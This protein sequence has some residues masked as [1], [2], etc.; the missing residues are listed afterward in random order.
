MTGRIEPVVVWQEVGV[1]YPEAAADALTGL[2]HR[3]P[4]G[5]FGLL[6]G[7]TGSGKSTVLHTVDASVPH[8]TGGT[9]RG[10]VL[11]AGRDT[12]EYAPR[13]LADVVAAVL[14]RPSDGFVADTVEDE[15]AYGMECLG[16]DPAVM[17]RRVEETL[18]LLGLVDLRRRAPGR[19]SGGQQQRVALAAAFAAHPKV[20]LLDEPTSAL[21][22]PAAEEVLSAVQR[23]VHDL[24]T[25]A[26]VAEHRLERVV[27]FADSA[28][29][30]EAGHAAGGPVDE[31]L[32]GSPVV[33]PVV[34][35]GRLLGWHPL[36][37]SV[38]DARRAA[39]ADDRL[40]EGA[41]AHPGG[42]SR[43]LPGGE[44]AA[45]LR[46]VHAGYGSVTAVRGVD[47]DLRTGQVHGLMG[48]NGAGKSTLLHV[49][50]GLHRPRSGSVRLRGVDP[51][52]LRPREVLRRVGL[53]PAD[54]G[55]LLLCDRV[56]AELALAD[57]H[58][59]LPPGR[60]RAVLAELLGD[61]MP[62]LDPAAHPRSLSSGQRLALALAVV[63]AHEPDLVLLDEPTRGLD[64]PTKARTTAVL[65]RIAAS[66][67]SVLLVTHDVELAAAACDHVSI[68][69]DGEVIASDRAD[70]VLRGSP[71]FAPQVAKVLAGIA[72]PGWL[73]VDD[74]ATGLGLGGRAEDLGRVLRPAGGGLP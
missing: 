39:L 73:T 19:L 22:P 69:A 48:R 21:D 11:T 4:S 40:R 16:V 15:I 37:L 42:P 51:A 20:L 38:R 12:A 65:R 28:V 31:A 7:R 50:V 47:L 72:E 60:T 64:Y 68:L 10:R 49:L 44:V 62:A 53:V 25:T 52:A 36:P 74:V 26:L 2:D 66:G 27:A 63:L 33:P 6:M 13:D 18:D 55:D 24:G 35:L 30:V 3:L 46:G 14:Q 61:L 23:I 8:A 9:L 32:A 1:R 71:A 5:E 59:D 58:G 17:R 57:R 70:V 34:A 43:Q 56:D 67:R 54:P 29:L 41:R 45:S